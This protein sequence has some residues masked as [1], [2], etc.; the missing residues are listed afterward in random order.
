MHPHGERPHARREREI[1]KLRYGFGD[2]YTYTLEEVGP[3]FNAVLPRAE[4]RWAGAA[5]HPFDSG[6]SHRG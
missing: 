3:I 1:I 4:H 2:G 5:V 6:G